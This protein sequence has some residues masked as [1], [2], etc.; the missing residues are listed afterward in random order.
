MTELVLY[1]NNHVF[2]TDLIGLSLG[3]VLH[4]E[5]GNEDRDPSSCCPCQ[6]FL[7]VFLDRSRLFIALDKEVDENSRREMDR[8]QRIAI[9]SY[10]IQALHGILRNKEFHTDFKFMETT[11]LK[12]VSKEIAAILNRKLKL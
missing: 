1:S 7:E 2:I 5:E 4:N 8:E 6:T 9:I 10:A 12:L 3:K 11:M